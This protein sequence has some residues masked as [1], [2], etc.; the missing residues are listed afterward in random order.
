[1]HLQI[2]QNKHKVKVQRWQTF[3]NLLKTHNK[4][5]NRDLLFIALNKT[6][7]SVIYNLS[8][9]LRRLTSNGNNLPF[10]IKWKDNVTPVERTHR[11]AYEFIV[12]CYKKVLKTKIT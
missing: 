5:N 1:M 8:S 9:H 2:Y 7:G 4:D 10:Q 12:E 11:Q 6:T 3:E